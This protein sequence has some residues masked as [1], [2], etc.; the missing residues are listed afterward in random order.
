VEAETGTDN[1][2]TGFKPWSFDDTFWE[3]ESSPY[4]QAHFIDTK[5]SSFNNLGAPAFALTNGN[6]A[7]NGYTTTAT[8]PFAAALKVGDQISVDVDNPVMRPLADGDSV[9]FIISLRT[10]D[11]VERFGF[12]TTLAFNDNQWSI[13]DSRGDE[14]ASGLS[15]E[16]SSSGF[17]LTLRLT[18][19]ETYQL[20][21]APRGGG[22]PL[23][24][25]RNARQARKGRDRQ[26][27]VR[28]VRKR[29]RRRR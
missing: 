4:K 5:P 21:I 26:D 14:T 20:T 17:K 2:G 29:Q 6:V 7:F 3:A 11:K 13:T 10:A 22:A 15:D 9:G 19:E 16:A 28:H 12:Y 24:L 25:R 18:G 23:D 27:T 1:G 8:R